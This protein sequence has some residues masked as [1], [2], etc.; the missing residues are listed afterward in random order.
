MGRKRLVQEEDVLRA[1]RDWMLHHGVPPTVKELQVALGVH[2]TRTVLRYLQGLEKGGSI[3]RWP[4][5]RGMRLK[6]IPDG[7]YDTKAVPVVGLVSAGSPTLAEE[8]IEGWIRLP[9]DYLEPRSAKHFLLRVRGDSMDRA[10]VKGG[11]IADGDIVLV[12]QQPAAHDGDIAVALIDGEATIKRLRRGPGYYVLCP[13]SGNHGH[14]P[15]VMD[16]DFRI[17]GIVRRVLKR[18]AE[19]CGWLDEEKEGRVDHD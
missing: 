17:L 10:A 7:G 1:L 19:F 6:R 15:I 5:S 3:E 13:E 11:C 8:A 18:G 16:S 14:R 9:S 2:S 12:R 4:G